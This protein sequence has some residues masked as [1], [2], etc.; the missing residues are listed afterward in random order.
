MVTCPW[1]TFPTSNAQWMMSGQHDFQLRF[2]RLIETKMT[3]AIRCVSHCLMLYEV[4]LTVYRKMKI[5]PAIPV[6]ACQGPKC[7]SNTKA[8][9][10][11]H[12]QTCLSKNQLIRWLSF[13]CF[14]HAPLQLLACYIG[15]VSSLPSDIPLP[16][17]QITSFM[18]NLVRTNIV[19]SLW[20]TPLL[21]NY[22]DPRLVSQA[23]C[24]PSE[25]ALQL[26]IPETCP[27]LGVCLHYTWREIE[28][29][30]MLRSGECV[31]MWIMWGLGLVVHFFT[32]FIYNHIEPYVILYKINFSSSQP[33]TPKP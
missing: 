11:N 13:P 10:K 19:I 5:C 31:G 12:L 15:S 23:L 24:P 4:K 30:I 18:K 16:T 33:T 27:A 21:A 9:G 2:Q 17:C 22:C 32:S 29:W 14:E 1:I 8:G 20:Q 6:V 26:A 28:G 25:H 7:I 3:A